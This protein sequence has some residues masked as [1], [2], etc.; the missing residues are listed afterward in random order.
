MKL[1]EME[2]CRFISKVFYPN[3]KNFEIVFQEK[4]ETCLEANGFDE[5]WWEAID[6]N[7]PDHSIF[8][9]I[10]HIYEDE[11]FEEE[12][13]YNLIEYYERLRNKVHAYIRKKL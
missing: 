3:P 7:D 10:L 2:S 8:L 1:V 9:N 11:N 12:G 4:I 13:L 6:F 5:C